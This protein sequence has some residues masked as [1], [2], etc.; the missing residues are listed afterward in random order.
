MNSNVLYP[1]TDTTINLLTPASISEKDRYLL[2]KLDEALERD[3][4]DKP[5]T[6]RVA[7][8][9]KVWSEIL[10]RQDPVISSLLSKIKHNYESHIK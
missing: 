4:L 2:H 5:S 3:L 6:Q 7:I 1:S 9:S 8:C 10:R